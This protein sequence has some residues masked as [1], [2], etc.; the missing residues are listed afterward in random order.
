LTQ[1]WCAILY[2]C[3]LRRSQEKSIWTRPPYKSTRRF[4]V[5]WIISKLCVIRSCDH[6]FIRAKVFFLMRPE[7][8]LRTAPTTQWRIS[9][10]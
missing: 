1:C 2:S 9:T 6:V 3:N 8:S 5:D 7:R 4:Q 10:T